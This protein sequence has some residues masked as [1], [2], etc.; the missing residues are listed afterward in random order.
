MKNTVTFNDGKDIIIEY[1]DHMNGVNKTN[2]KIHI[3]Y[4]FLYFFACNPKRD[5]RGKIWSRVFSPEHPKSD[6][7]P[8]FTPLNET[9]SIST[10]F[11]SGASPPLPSRMKMYSWLSGLWPC[12]TGLPNVCSTSRSRAVYM[13]NHVMNN[14][15]YHKLLVHGVETEKKSNPWK[16]TW[17]DL[18]WCNFFGA[19]T[20]I[21]PVRGR[22]KERCVT[23]KSSSGNLGNWVSLVTSPSRQSHL[24]SE[25]KWWLFLAFLQ[26][27]NLKSSELWRP[28][29]WTLVLGS[30]KKIWFPKTRSSCCCLCC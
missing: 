7:N 24:Q 17:F 15:L 25:T 4:I 5:L 21:K 13:L 12:P 10:P 28:E 18:F 3:K 22:T 9:T 23:G 6:Q 8:K 2:K 1:L 20:N 11:V 16:A 30:L 14:E 19:G 27:E 26:K 29:W